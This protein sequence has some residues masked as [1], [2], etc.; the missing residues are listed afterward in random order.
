MEI[1][2]EYVIL[3]VMATCLCIG[4]LI[5]HSLNFIPNKYIPLILAVL[6]VVINSWSNNWCF[7]LDI[8]LGGMASG[9]AATGLFEGGK[10]L[11]KKEV[12]N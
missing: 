10:H 2:N 3:I 9:L 8:F 6:G 7:T 11:L 4:F 5:K 12:K 1:I